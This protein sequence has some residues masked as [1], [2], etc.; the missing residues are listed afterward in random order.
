MTRL[1]PAPVAPPGTSAGDE[2][3]CHAGLAAVSRSLR[4]AFVLLG[5]LM[6][7]LVLW[8]LTFGGY[9]TV[10]PQENVLVLR[11]G[12]LVAAHKEGWHWV[13]PQPVHELVRIPTS[14]RTIATMAFWPARQVSMMEDENAPR[15]APL[16]PGVDGYLLT[17]DANVVHTA[18]TLN[19]RVTDPQAYYLRF[20]CPAD[21]RKP[22]DILRHG[23]TGLVVGPRG[24]ET[25]LRHLLETAVIHE[26]AVRQVDAALYQDAKAFNDDVAA[27]LGRMVTER[28]LGIAVNSVV[29]TEKT[30]P[31]ATM[32]AFQQVVSAMQES[33]NAILQARRYAT[34]T[35]GQGRADAARLLAEAETYRKRI[36]SDV[37]AEGIYFQ[38]ILTEFRANPATVLFALYSDTLAT[39]LDQA[40]DKFIVR[41]NET[42]RQEV[43]VQINPEPARPKPAIPAEGADE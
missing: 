13:F 30:P 18:W 22:D 12:R 43:R 34:R 23:E 41:T 16:K 21:P 28:R 42:G 5:L 7:G 20:L 24:P 40:T 10:G 37:A 19:Y 8:Y 9:F 33:Q 32:A 2:V 3:A 31:G 38:R 36:V 35:Q 6:V 15:E 27:R 14:Q 29:L 11:F 1:P 25:L 26:A 4:V 17:G 39:V